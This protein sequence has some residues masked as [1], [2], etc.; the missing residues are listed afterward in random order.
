MV[1]IWR[2]NLWNHKCKSFLKLDQFRYKILGKNPSQN[3]TLSSLKRNWWKFNLDR[4]CGLKPRLEPGTAVTFQSNV[5]KRVEAG[6]EGQSAIR[7]GSTKLRT[8]S[9]VIKAKSV[10]K[11]ASDSP[12]DQ[13]G[14]RRPDREGRKRW[15]WNK[16]KW[17][18]NT[19]T[20]RQIWGTCGHRY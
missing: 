12:T 6:R 9:A 4:H 15:G 5:T 11:S 20:A 8:S 19:R 17:P 10:E 14:R 16:K 7:T 18:R 2:R 1:K 3:R 13:G